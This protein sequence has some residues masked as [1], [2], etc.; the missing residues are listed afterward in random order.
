MEKLQNQKR[1]RAEIVVRMPKIIGF[2]DKMRRAVRL[3][4]PTISSQDGAVFVFPFIEQKIAGL[5]DG[6]QMVSY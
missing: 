4:K 5:A 3:D 2:R 6:L 1:S